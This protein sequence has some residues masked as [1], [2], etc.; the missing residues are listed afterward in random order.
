MSDTNATDSTKPEDLK[1][2]KPQRSALG[3]RL[4]VGL[5]GLAV[6]GVVGQQIWTMRLWE[7][8]QHEDVAVT[9]V[10]TR[11]AA[12]ESALASQQAL[13]HEMA[14]L[15]QSFLRDRLVLQL[16]RIEEQIDAGWQIWL[17]TGNSKQL[18]QALESGQHV[19][20]NAT[21]AEAQVLR[22]A[23]ARDL[24][25]IANRQ[26][27][28][29]RETVQQL[30]G[31]IASIDKLPLQQEHR[32]QAAPSEM[33]NTSLPDTEALTLMDKA[34]AIVTRVG[35]EIWQSIRRMVRV[36]RL[37]QAEPALI[38][39]EQKVFLQQGLRMLLL[40]ARHALVQR[41]AAVYQ[42]SLSQAHRWIAKYFDGADALVRG[43]LDLLQRLV[44]IQVDP[45]AVNF[46]ATR[47]A[48]DAL[49][50]TLLGA[51]VVP[52]VDPAAETTVPAGTTPTEAAGKG[53]AT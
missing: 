16:D 32:L 19:L 10:D 5:V 49:R 20:A 35:E 36:Q 44:S 48:L 23:M 47:Q 41:N 3:K 37:D 4:I 38:A 53:S 14:V 40:D 24:A 45:A 17:I 46:D 52:S 1:I 15:R 34:R 42:Q 2:K 13:Q 12:L 18:G 43:D 8:L 31:V 7:R 51:D 28:D 9:S 30:D 25:G 33:A 27:L 22:Q 50:N 11:L 29:L 21:M 39:P 26:V 6:I